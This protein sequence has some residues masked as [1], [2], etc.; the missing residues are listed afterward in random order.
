MT[1]TTFLF[2]WYATSTLVV[3]VLFPLYIAWPQIAASFSMSSWRFTDNL[4]LLAMGLFLV[5]GMSFLWRLA[6]AL[7]RS[8]AACIACSMLLGPIGLVIVLAV[9]ANIVRAR[10]SK[11]KA[12]IERDSSCR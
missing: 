1:H 9:M 11:T 10:G 8:G 6:G 2:R 3:L 5:I 4:L 7:G 12:E